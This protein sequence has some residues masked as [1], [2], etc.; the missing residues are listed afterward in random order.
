MKRFPFL[1]VIFAA[2]LIAAVF[3][4]IERVEKKPEPQHERISRYTPQAVKEGNGKITKQRPVQATPQKQ[5]K[6]VAIIIDDIG[7]DLHALRLLAEIPAPLAFSVLPY[8]PHSAEAIEYLHQ[9]KREILLHLPM[10]PLSYPK[11]APGP[12]ALMVNMDEQQIRR[13]L[14]DDLA[15][16]PY[17]SGVNNHMGSRFMEDFKRLSVLMEEL[18]KRNLY[19][20][21]SRTTAHSKGLEA[22]VRTGIHF[23]A[24]DLFIDHEHGYEAAFQNLLTVSKQDKGYSRP[25]LLI[26]HPHPDTIRAI[27]TIIPLWKHEGIRIVD[28]K[29]V[30]KRVT[31]NEY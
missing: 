14:N 17:V 19:F 6:H 27:K 7:F 25:L 9:R 10:E 28:V 18:E 4:I 24:R 22:A 8:T 5:S 15:V 20:V 12:G 13:Q 16:V 1:S 31:K 26:G 2:A 21:D 29:T 11:E 23:A 3:I 30:P